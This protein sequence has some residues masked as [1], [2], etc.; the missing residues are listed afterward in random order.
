[1]LLLVLMSEQLGVW[2]GYPDAE[3]QGSLRISLKSPGW[4][5]GQCTARW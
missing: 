4:S 1:M 2:S 3:V 5:I